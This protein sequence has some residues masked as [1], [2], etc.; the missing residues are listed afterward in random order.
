M[1]SLFDHLHL[2]E[3]LAQREPLGLFTDFDGTIS[4]IAPSPNDARILPGSYAHLASLSN[5]LPLLAIVSGRPVQ[6]LAEM[7]G[8]PKAIY[9]GNHGLEKMRDDKVIDEK[10]VGEHHK[11]VHQAVEMVKKELGELTGML[12]EDKGPIVS[13][14]YRGCAESSS[15]ERKILSLL[16]K[17]AQEGRIK[18][19]QGRMVVEVQPPVDFS[20]GIAVFELINER[21]LRS[22]IYLGDDV[23][24]IDALKSVRRSLRGCPFVGIGVAVVEEGTSREVSD[25][26]DF[27]LQGTQEVNVFLEWLGEI[28]P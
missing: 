23:T 9:I 2:V 6:A 24:D 18:I 13:L 25:A 19:R 1:P 15:I 10:D 27:T 5:K 20:K 17:P 28:I 11:A 4:D 3:Q 14:H 26:A 21:S 8:I 7:V 16:E 22:A 12:Y